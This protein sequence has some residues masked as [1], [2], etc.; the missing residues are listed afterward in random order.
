MRGPATPGGLERSTCPAALTCARTA[1]CRLKASTSADTDGQALTMS[2]PPETM[3]S[4]SSHSTPAVDAPCWHCSSYAGPD[5]SGSHAL[6]L[7]DGRR[8]VQAS[9]STGCAS[10]EREPGADDEPGPPAV[11]QIGQ[12]QSA[13]VVAWTL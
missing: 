8:A 11:V 12:R 9:P 5:P 6:C 4:M 13:R 2:R 1:A 10:F 3:L 7:H